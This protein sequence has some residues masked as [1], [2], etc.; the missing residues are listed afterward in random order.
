MGIAI[1]SG[2]YTM[3]VGIPSLRVSTIPLLYNISLLFHIRSLY[4]TYIRLWR[5]RESY[6]TYIGIYILSHIRL[7]RR[8]RGIDDVIY[9]PFIQS[10]YIYAFGD[11]VYENRVVN[12]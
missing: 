11:F 1:R 2:V 3:A 6:C 7:C 4:I 5:Q 8:D 9:I 12:Y 10:V